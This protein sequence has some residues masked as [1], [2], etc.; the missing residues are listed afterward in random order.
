ML[1]NKDN[2][3]NHITRRVK[4]VEFDGFEVKLKQMGIKQQLEVEA[5]NVKKASISDLVF[6]VLIRC[7]VDENDSPLFDDESVAELPTEIAIKLFDECL[8]LNSLAKNDLEDR[9]KNS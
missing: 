6:P 5:I 7:C 4:V 3:K 1:L 8:A 2:L 9:A